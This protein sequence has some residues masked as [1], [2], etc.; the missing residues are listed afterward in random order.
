MITSPKSFL[1]Y[2]AI[3]LTGLAAGLFLAW[4]VS[5][6]PG[7]QRVSDGSYLESMQSINRAILNPAFF[8]I[9]LGPVFA[10]SATAF[11]HYPARTPFLLL[12]GA[13]LLYLIGTF[14]VTAWGNVPL[15][16]QL[17]VLQ[18]A[19]LSPQ[20]A[21][22]FRAQYETRWNRFHWLRTIASVGAFC[23][24]LLAAFLK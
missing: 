8:L 22:S 20:Q 7:T 14:G 21:Q 24:A 16:D 17:E 3:L 10:L 4:A 12:F 23:A 11:H 19:D 13:A 5:V 1:L 18:L 2:L 15:N 6:L 9:F